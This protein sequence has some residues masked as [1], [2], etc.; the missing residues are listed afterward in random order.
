[1]LSRS[2]SIV[3]SEINNIYKWVLHNLRSFIV[4]RSS[5]YFN[6]DAC[7]VT[8]ENTI[9]NTAAK[10]STR[11]FPTTTKVN[12]WRI[13]SHSLW[14]LFGDDLFR[15]II[16]FR[17]ITKPIGHT[18]HTQS[19][20]SSYRP[21][22]EGNNASLCSF[23]KVRRTFTWLIM[24]SKFDAQN[25]LRISPLFFSLLS[26]SNFIEVRNFKKLC[27]FSRNW[28][29]TIEGNGFLLRTKSSM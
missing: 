11:L 12:E 8:Y 6:R 4:W 18:H 5:L 3:Q 13:V 2:K 1:M 25:A 16:A 24:H 26:P 21:P 14:F 19:L 27:C 22:S 23:F 15:L 7:H 29:H 10:S 20:L 17:F 9:Q 28:N